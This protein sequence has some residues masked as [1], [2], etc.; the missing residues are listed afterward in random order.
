MHTWLFCDGRV[1]DNNDTSSDDNHYG[2]NDQHAPVG[3]VQ[4][5]LRAE[6]RQ[7]VIQMFVGLLYRVLTMRSNYDDHK[8]HGY[9]DGHNNLRDSSIS[10]SN[11]DNGHKGPTHFHDS[12]A[13]GL[14][15]LVC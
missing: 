7:L 13:A 12:A 14:Q 10:H 4:V 8:Q 3:R 9:C 11:G 5:F 2:D 6:F 15:V 1:N